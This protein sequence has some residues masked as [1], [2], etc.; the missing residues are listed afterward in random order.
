[1]GHKDFDYWFRLNEDWERSYIHYRLDTLSTLLHAA[2]KHVL[3][4]ESVSWIPSL[5]ITTR[6]LTRVMLD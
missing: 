1:M 4:R 3:D 5:C 6:G 2:N